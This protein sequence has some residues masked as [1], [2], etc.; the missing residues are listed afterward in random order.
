LESRKDESPPKAKRYKQNT[1]EYDCATSTLR[2]NHYPS[3][4]DI[5]FLRTT[6][7]YFKFGHKRPRDFN[8][9][10]AAKKPIEGNFIGSLRLPC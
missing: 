3:K 1:V 6:R 7:L 9:V 2:R 8:P 5:I 4:Q 10:S